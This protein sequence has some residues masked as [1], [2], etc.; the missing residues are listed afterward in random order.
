MFRVHARFS[1]APTILKFDN[2]I[3]AKIKKIY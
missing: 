3:T 1:I 2:N